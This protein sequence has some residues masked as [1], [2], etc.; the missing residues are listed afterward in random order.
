MIKI[1]LFLVIMVCS[2]A[3]PFHVQG[4]PGPYTERKQAIQGT[5]L[6]DVSSMGGGIDMARQY[7]KYVIKDD[8]ISSYSWDEKKK[9]WVKVFTVPFQLIYYYNEGYMTGYNIVYQSP[10]GYEVRMCTGDV[11]DDGK[12]DIWSSDSLFH[13]KQ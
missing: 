13:T 11:N 1:R 3:L 6:A 4:K 8:S 7:G 9:I 5:Y 12:M 2:I 10:Y